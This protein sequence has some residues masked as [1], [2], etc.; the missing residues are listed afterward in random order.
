MPYRDYLQGLAPGLL[1]RIDEAQQEIDW[2]RNA[3]GPDLL[4]LATDQLGFKN[5]SGIADGMT[6]VQ[7][8]NLDSATLRERLRPHYAEL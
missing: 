7:L 3:S 1:H 6:A 2:I 4:N 5:L 8:G